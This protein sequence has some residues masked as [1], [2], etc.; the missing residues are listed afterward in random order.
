MTRSTEKYSPL[1]EETVL[2]LKEK[3]LQAAQQS[4]DILSWAQKEYDLLTDVEVPE[5]DS[6]Q[7]YLFLDGLRGCIN[8]RKMTI[9]MKN[10]T[11]YLLKTIMY[12][13]LWM[14]SVDGKTTCIE[15]I[16]RCK[17]FESE[18]TKI[19]R[20][21]NMNLS[22]SI[23][24]R[25][26]IKGIIFND[27]SEEEIEEMI[28]H[29]FDTINN[30]LVIR[31][32][33]MAREFKKWVEEST[34]IMEADKKVVAEIMDTPFFIDESKIKDYIHHPKE[35]GYKALQF[36]L[37]ITAY[38]T[39]IPGAQIEIQLKSQKMEEEAESGKASHE[40][41]KKTGG[42]TT[43]ELTDTTTSS[44]LSLSSLVILVISS[45]KFFVCSANCL[46]CSATTAK[47]LP[48]S[49]ALALSIEALSAKR[50]VWLDILSIIPAIFSTFLVFSC[51]LCIDSV[52]DLLVSVICSD[53]FLN[54]SIT[55]IF[56]CIL[57]LELT[58]S[59]TI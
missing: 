58:A 53:C 37:S 56:F 13:I 39:N 5:E 26:G 40:V 2:K 15:L 50:L 19:L 11:S 25:F 51:N 23:R 12:L 59:S 22:T 43:E 20:K 42:H 32:I 14:N 45:V 7:F 27:A 46:I 28:E 36:T 10:E 34:E 47:P 18:L 4:N 30:V 3:H 6:K 24:D 31:N 17:S 21:A 49:P 57:S 29:I 35:N 1:S 44:A 54:S 48:A 38:S 52:T 16:A 41:Y 33:K 9:K 8:Y 55:T